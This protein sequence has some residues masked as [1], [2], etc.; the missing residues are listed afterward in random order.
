MRGS[1]DGRWTQGE[2]HGLC[3]LFGGQTWQDSRREGGPRC[4]RAESHTVD[5]GSA[6]GGEDR[7]SPAIH[8]SGFCVKSHHPGDSSRG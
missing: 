2:G 1:E 7:Q 3:S 8:S 6:R 5:G 4:A